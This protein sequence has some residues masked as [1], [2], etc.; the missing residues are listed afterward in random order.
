MRTLK[1]LSTAMLKG[2]FRDKMAFFFAVI[3]PLMFL[4]LFGGI[5]TDQGTSMQVLYPSILVLGLYFL[6]SGHNRPGGGFVGGLVVG[7]ALALRYVSGGAAAVRSTF[8]IPPH[9]ILG[10]GLLLAAFW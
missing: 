8:R 7:A 9:V 3:F 10:T 4:V 1:A 2:F 5:L 6:F